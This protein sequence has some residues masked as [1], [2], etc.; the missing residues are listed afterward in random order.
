MIEYITIGGLVEPLIHNKYLHTF[1]S[2][3]FLSIII[4]A[5][6]P[7]YHELFRSWQLQPAMSVYSHMTS[8]EPKL[9]RHF[10]PSRVSTEVYTLLLFPFRFLSNIRSFSRFIASC[11]PSSGVV[12]GN[13]SVSGIDRRLTRDS[14]AQESR[15]SRII[16]P[17]RQ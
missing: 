13:Y 15:G 9:R 11:H 14:R 2:S 7:C 10:L 1:S 5:I 17:F 16:W 8:E 6:Q 4:T 3:V 12:D